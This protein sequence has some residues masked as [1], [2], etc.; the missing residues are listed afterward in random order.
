MKRTL[1]LIPI[2]LLALP[3]KAQQK[4]SYAYDAAGNRTSRTVVLPTRSA[5]A[6]A[7]NPADSVFFRETLA[8]N[9]VKIY[10]N[11]VQSTLTVSI[12]RY[13]PSFGGELTL[14][15]IS[16]TMLYRTRIAGETSSIDMSRYLPGTYLLHIL[17]KGEKSVWKVIKQ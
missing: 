6:A 16:G 4:L 17:L 7:T 13:E 15:S 3:V 1:Y 9:P 10:P 5:D 14:F 8:G 11:P 2:L 12:D